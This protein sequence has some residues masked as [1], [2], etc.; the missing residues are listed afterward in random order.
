V[1]E[2]VPELDKVKANLPAEDRFRLAKVLAML[3]TPPAAPQTETPPGETEPVV[4]LSPIGRIPA[5]SLA[6]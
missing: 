1:I 4:D 5:P 3:P 6:A 2:L